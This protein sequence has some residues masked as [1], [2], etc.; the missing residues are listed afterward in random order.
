MGSVE[1]LFFDLN[2]FFASVEQQDDPRLRG[3]PI[4]VLPA[5]S[6]GTCVITASYEAKAFGIST[7]T[8]LKEARRLCPDLV[9]IPARHEVYIDYHDRIL[10][11]V[12]RHL[13]VEE[14]CSIDEGVCRLI[15]DEQFHDHLLRLVRTLARRLHLHA[16]GRLA[17]A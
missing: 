5:D 2:A 11:E 12:R 10:K 1:F 7:G 8:R 14:V 15:G 6:E 9:V 17:H 16:D 4:G 3:K 13:P